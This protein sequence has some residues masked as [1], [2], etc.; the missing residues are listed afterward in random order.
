[1]S[2]RVAGN[3]LSTTVSKRP[4][5]SNRSI[6]SSHGSQ[7]RRKLTV[8]NRR[9][10]N[11]HAT[12]AE[13]DSPAAKRVKPATQTSLPRRSPFEHKRNEA[14]N[15]CRVEKR[16]S[17]VCL[18]SSEAKN[19]W[20]R[21]VFWTA[22]VGSLSRLVGVAIGEKGTTTWSAAP[23]TLPFG[24]CTL[25]IQNLRTFSALRYSSLQT[26]THMHSLFV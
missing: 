2:L 21:E 6:I 17:P 14:S 23:A 24:N 8:A 25:P 15:V 16:L 10:K 13:L 18:C 7:A 22:W 26:D 4:K 3:C 12:E 9:L 11:L 19:A 1:M 20:L 5:H